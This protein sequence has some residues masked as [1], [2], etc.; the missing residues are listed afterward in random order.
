[1]YRKI[2]MLFGT[3]PFKN[4][5]RAYITKLFIHPFYFLQIILSDIFLIQ[6]D[7]YSHSIVEGGFEEMS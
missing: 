7:F 1:M 2:N 4:L 5:T 6:Q 3:S